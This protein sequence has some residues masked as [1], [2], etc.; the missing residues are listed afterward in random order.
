M[1]PGPG[2]RV[3]EIDVDKRHAPAR[4]DEQVHGVEIAGQRGGAVRT[5]AARA[6]AE[7]VREGRGDRR[8]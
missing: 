7:H 3:F 1:G 6:T 4:V 8:L 2:G 5:Q